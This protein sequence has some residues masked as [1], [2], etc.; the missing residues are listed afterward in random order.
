MIKVNLNICRHIFVSTYNNNIPNSTSKRS[1][2]LCMR[3]LM[4]A[5]TTK[6]FN[7]NKAILN[8]NKEYNCISVFL[9]NIC[10]QW[11]ELD[12]DDLWKI[13]LLEK[14]WSY[15]VRQ[16]TF[17]YISLIV[18]RMYCIWINSV[19]TLTYFT[20]MLPFFIIVRKHKKRT[21][22]WNGLQQLKKDIIKDLGSYDF[23][24]AKW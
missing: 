9:I 19:G 13:K 22:T 11:V 12:E 21:E 14:L 23:Q 5:F 20:P 17:S 8:E 7:E 1:Y 3:T 16:G 10:Q 24:K 18:L 2:Q 15:K 6:V 4:E